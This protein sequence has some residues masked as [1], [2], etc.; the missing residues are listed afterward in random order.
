MADTQQQLEEALQARHRWLTGRT[1]QSITIGDKTI[2]YSVDGLKQ[3]DA[4]IAELRRQLSRR[5]RARNRIF[6][7]VPD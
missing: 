3:L 6:Y 1:R 2:T 5:P 4:Y 7:G